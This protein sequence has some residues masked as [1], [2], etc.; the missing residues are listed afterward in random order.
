M[1][2][3]SSSARDKGKVCENQF[4]GEDDIFGFMQSTLYSIFYAN[5]EKLEIHPK[6]ETQVN[7]LTQRSQ[8]QEGDRGEEDTFS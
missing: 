1:K 5:N 6:K 7:I 8:T 4:T 3:K 2:S